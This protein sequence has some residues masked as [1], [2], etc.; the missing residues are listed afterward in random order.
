MSLLRVQLG[1]PRY[2]AENPYCSRL[3]GFFYFPNKGCTNTQ[4]LARVGNPWPLRRKTPVLRLMHG[5]GSPNL[6]ERVR[7]G[8]G[9]ADRE[10]ANVE[11]AGAVLQKILL[12]ESHRTNAPQVQN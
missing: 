2:Q 1:E 7:Q 4:K 3:C 11:W 6:Q 5:S 10:D 9:R 12:C 8:R